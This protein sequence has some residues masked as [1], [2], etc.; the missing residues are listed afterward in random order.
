MARPQT[1]QNLGG[2]CAPQS[3]IHYLY[4]LDSVVVVLRARDCR[5]QGPPQLKLL[6]QLKLVQT[7]RCGYRHARL[8]K[9]LNQLKLG[10]RCQ[11]G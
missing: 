9:S 10:R 2:V 4:Q 3:Q 11:C 6:I 7:C 8:Q 5:Y 1:G